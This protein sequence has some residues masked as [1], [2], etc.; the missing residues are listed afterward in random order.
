MVKGDR[1][2]SFFQ[3]VIESTVEMKFEQT[4]A[5]DA[6]CIQKLPMLLSQKWL[7]LNWQLSLQ[8]PQDTF[9]DQAVLFL[10]HIVARKVN[11][12]AS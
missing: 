10:C 11:I 4:N 12:N 8:G 5:S 6:P 1:A 9:E 7:F 3:C 2:C